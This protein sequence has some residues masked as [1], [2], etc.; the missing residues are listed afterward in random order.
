MASKERKLVGQVGVDSGQI[1]LTDPC[2]VSGFISDET[3]ADDLNE[4]SQKQPQAAYPY[5]Y[6]G[7]CH[8]TCNVDGAG[9]LENVAGVC[10]SSGHGDGVYPVYVEYG[11]EGRVARVTI[12]FM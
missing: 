2:Y 1:M 7:A 5:S 6:D 12:E 11:E 3:N 4:A 10:V 9:Q 8:A